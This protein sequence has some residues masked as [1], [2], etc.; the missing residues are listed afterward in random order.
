MAYA[1]EPN[2]HAEAPHQSLWKAVML[3]EFQALQDQHTWILVPPPKYYKPLGCKWMFHTKFNM[4]GSIARYKARLVSQGYNEI[5]GIDYMKTFSPVA[6]HTIA[7]L[8]ITITAYYKWAIS[9]L[10][11]S[12]AFLH[13]ELQERLFMKQPPNF[14]HQNSA[15]TS[16]NSTKPFMA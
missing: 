5:E 15:T 4:D 9:E 14:S 3:E 8:L 7:R 1:Q 2:S 11:V 10:D 6:K 13:G 12:N 16:A